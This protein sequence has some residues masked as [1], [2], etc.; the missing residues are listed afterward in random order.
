M[1]G[2][3]WLKGVGGWHMFWCCSGREEKG[4]KGREVPGAGVSPAL[5][6]SNGAPITRP[7]AAQVKEATP[8]A[9]T[10]KALAR[11]SKNTT[12]GSLNHDFNFVFSVFGH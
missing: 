6:L 12:R 1:K 8:K 3:V 7:V 2:L 5:G 9:V 4:T 10:P 11:T